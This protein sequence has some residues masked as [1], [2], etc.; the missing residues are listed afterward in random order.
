[1]R[2]NFSVED[3]HS[4]AA[5]QEGD[6][7]RELPQCWPVTGLCG[8]RPHWDEAIYLGGWGGDK[9]VCKAVSASQPEWRGGENAPGSW[10]KE[11]ITHRSTWEWWVAILR[12]VTNGD[13]FVNLLRYMGF[14]DAYLGRHRF[15]K[16]SQIYIYLSGFLKTITP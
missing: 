8:H 7:S 14:R 16:S 2:A 13:V 9:C 3:G 10:G 6:A 4:F 15:Q 11:I 1:M 12:L 5:E